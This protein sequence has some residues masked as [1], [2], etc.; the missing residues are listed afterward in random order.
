[1]FQLAI[2]PFQQYALHFL[3][4]IG[5]GALSKKYWFWTSLIIGL[6]KESFDEISYG[7]FDYVD[8]GFTVI[9]GYLGYLLRNSIKS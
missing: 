2:T 1:M 9:G 4:G 7:G 8:L 6:A 5:I 3:V